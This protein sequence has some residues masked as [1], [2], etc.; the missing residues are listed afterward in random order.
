VIKLNPD[1]K[2]IKTQLRLLRKQLRECKALIPH[3]KA[4]IEQ[5]DVEVAKSFQENKKGTKRSYATSI[6]HHQQLLA[7]QRRLTNDIYELKIQKE[8]LEQGSERLKIE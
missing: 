6:F 7:L 3:S 2:R 8:K 1:L 4:A 5:L